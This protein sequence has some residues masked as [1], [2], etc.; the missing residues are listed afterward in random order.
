M[1]LPWSG[2]EAGVEIENGHKS[3]GWICN[4]TVINLFEHGNVNVE[5]LFVPQDE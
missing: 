3:I 2:M 5:L 4:A 1:A